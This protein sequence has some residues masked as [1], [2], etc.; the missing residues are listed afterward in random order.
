MVS[1]FFMT[2]HTFTFLINKNLCQYTEELILFSIICVCVNVIYAVLMVN[3]KIKTLLS[4][5]LD[6]IR[7]VQNKSS[8]AEKSNETNKSNNSKTS[9]QTQNPG[10]DLNYEGAKSDEIKKSKQSNN[11]KLEK[12]STHSRDHE[13]MIPQEQKIFAEENDTNLINQSADTKSVKSDNKDVVIYLHNQED[14]A[15]TNCTGE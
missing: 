6:C 2:S 3:V 7:P 14:D 1:F 4:F 10:N 8:E 5:S 15:L 12:M 11:E 9:K 13:N